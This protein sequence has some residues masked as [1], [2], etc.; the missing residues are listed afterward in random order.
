MTQ[1]AASGVPGAAFCRILIVRA[2]MADYTSDDCH[3][4]LSRSSLT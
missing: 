3:A 2:L 1:K 4:R